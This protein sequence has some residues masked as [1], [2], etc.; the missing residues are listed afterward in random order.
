MTELYLAVRDAYP[1]KALA[2]TRVLALSGM[3]SLSLELWHE[4][5]SKQVKNDAPIDTYIYSDV[6]LSRGIDA[7]MA[8]GLVALTQYTR[9]SRLVFAEGTF[10]RDGFNTILQWMVVHRA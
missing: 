8:E 10:K 9:P 6:L 2:H 7:A 3:T 1:T 4:S 5:L